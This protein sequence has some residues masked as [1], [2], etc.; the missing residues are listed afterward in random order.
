[1]TDTQFKPM[2][3]SDWDEN[4]ITFPCAAQPKIDGVRAMHMLG[5]L[6]GRS[7]KKHANK[8]TTEKFSHP[9]LAGL[10]GEMAADD[11]T[12]P[13]LCTLTS[14]ALSSIQG[15]PDIRWYLFDYVTER[16]EL[17]PYQER[18]LAMLDR[19]HELKD[20]VEHLAMHLKIVPSVVCNNMEELLALEELWL[21]EGY[22]GVIIRKPDAPFKRGRSTV[23][24]GGL[25]RIKRFIEE[26][27]EVIGI[28]EG[29]T[30]LNEKQTNELGNSFRSTHQENMVPNGQVG[31]LTCRMLK[32][33]FDPQKKDKL[34]LAK[35]QI[36]TV[37][38]GKMTADQ[39]K[40]Y[41][42]NPH[43]IVN[44]I[45][46]FKFFPKGGKDK[47]RFPTYVTIRPKSDMGG[48]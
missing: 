8:H 32:D 31:S 37:S 13:D 45:V 28:E 1:M 39:R 23:R 18:Y 43:E 48:E 6:T 11:V 42:Q 10:D 34:L 40:Y 9:A 21:D 35:G 44:Q 2:L 41:F 3:A 7:L 26:E 24:E 16:T 12:H 46:K 22:E 4:K 36:V 25:L 38:P 33:V 15:E 17:M 47:P 30:N 20:E 29:Q 27:A 5:G 19:V 14:S